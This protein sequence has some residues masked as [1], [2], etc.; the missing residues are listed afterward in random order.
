[1]AIPLWQAGHRPGRRSRRL[2]ASKEAKV[3]S[4]HPCGDRGAEQ[5]VSLGCI[6][7]AGSP[8]AWR[9]CVQGA[10]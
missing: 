5:G 2:T 8:C 6:S 4:G 10:P 3:N 9:V 1:M 7:L